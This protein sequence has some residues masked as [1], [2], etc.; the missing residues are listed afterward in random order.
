MS[1]N[2][3][4][5]VLDTSPELQPEGTYRFAMNKV[6]S[7]LDATVRDEF[8][9]KY[10]PTSSSKD[11]V[12]SVY[13]DY[14]KT[15]LFRVNRISLLTEEVE[16]VLI[17][18]ARLNIQGTQ[19]IKGVS[20]KNFRSDIIVVWTD[21]VNPVRYLNV[22]TMNLQLNSKKEFKSDSE[23]SKL[24]FFPDLQV[25]DVPRVKVNDAGGTL[26]SGTYSLAIAYQT[27]DNFITD[28]CF[29]SNP[30]FITGGVSSQEFKK[31]AGVK[32]SSPTTK[33]ITFSVD[34]LDLNFPKVVYAIIQ[35]NGTEESAFIAMVKDIPKIGT[36]SF[37]FTGSEFVEQLTVEDVLIKKA[38]YTSAKTLTIT[39]DQLWFANLKTKP[40]IDYQQYANNIKAEWVYADHVSLNGVRGSYKDGNVIY[41]DKSFM[42]GEVVSL[43]I[44]LIRKNGQRT[45]AFHIPGRLPRPINLERPELENTLV[46][47]L[48][49]TYPDMEYLRKDYNISEEA[50]YFH[51][52]DT[53]SKR[54]FES[55]L[56]GEM[57][58]WENEEVYPD[59][60]PE[61]AGLP[62]RHHRLPSIGSLINFG[63]SLMDE[64]LTE[65]TAAKFVL[66]INTGSTELSGNQ[67]FMTLQQ[68]RINFNRG[69]DVTVS[70][71]VKLVSDGLNH[72]EAFAVIKLFSADGSLK[73]VLLNQ[74]E[75]DNS[76][77]GSYVLVA[78]IES[79]NS[80]FVAVD[81]GDYLEYSFFGGITREGS[82]TIN[83][84]EKMLSD[85]GTIFSKKLGIALWNIQIPQELEDEI[86]GY[87]IFYGK[88]DFNNATVL[89]YSPIID[90]NSPNFATN[91]IPGAKV[92]L[93]SPDFLAN[94]TYPS[95]PV[96]YLCTE[97]GITGKDEQSPNRM[98]DYSTGMLNQ[99]YYPVTDVD[100][101][102]LKVT[103]VLY[104][105]Y[106]PDTM[107]ATSL[108]C[109]VVNG[110]TTTGRAYVSLRV[111]RKN[112]YTTFYSTPL[113]STG[114]IF[115]TPEPGIYATGSLYGGDTYFGE[116]AF[117]KSKFVDIDNEGN[118]E[119][120]GY[121]NLDAVYSWFTFSVLN[122]NLRYAGENFGEQYYPLSN[123]PQSFLTGGDTFALKHCCTVDNYVRIDPLTK[124][125][126][127][128]HG[129]FVFN[130][131]V[132][133]T[134]IFPNRIA[135][136]SLIA[137][138][139]SGSSAK[140]FLVLDYYEM[141]KNKGE[142]VN[143]EWFN[144]TLLIHHEDAL[145]TTVPETRMFTKD[146]EVALGTGKLFSM[147]PKA[148]FTVEGGYAG[149]QHMGS[150]R[151]TKAGYFFVDDRR[152]KVFLL[153]D[154][155]KEISNSGMKTFFR[156]NSI[157]YMTKGDAP[158]LTGGVGY[159]VGFDDTFNRI[160]LHKKDFIIDGERTKSNNYTLSYSIE[161]EKWVSFHSY[162]PNHLFVH[163]NKLYAAKGYNLF[164]HND[165]ETRATYYNDEQQKTFV[166]IVFNPPTSFKKLFYAFLWDTSCYD[167]N[168][169]LHP[170]N[171][172]DKVLVY[173]NLQVSGEVGLD[174]KIR[175]LDGSWR[176]NQF[177][178]L[179]PQEKYGKNFLDKTGMFNS[180]V[181]D[182]QMDYRI[183]KRFIGDWIILRLINTNSDNYIVYLHSSDAFF[184]KIS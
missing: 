171:T 151:V 99:N 155:L 108:S 129:I 126:N 107:R 83:A 152:G 104:E 39:N 25:P 125:L 184:R 95:M 19:Q 35:R 165:P 58:Y 181:V 133:Y 40:Q 1:R 113:V 127:T 143:I 166:D 132:N 59:W 88:R 135:G 86:I 174:G 117:F 87:E 76:D 177:R 65:S 134:Y 98:I 161:S 30:V 147:A 22:S 33:S 123:I 122:T 77:D 17:S 26:I 145:F 91:L 70:W 82:I 41:L 84:L 38:H 51:M 172:F 9:T 49:E 24:N 71:D 34:N 131:D 137:S 57:G 8:G 158:F 36:D 116:Y 173:N 167:S 60:F 101:K 139:D 37:E 63:T 12:G 23:V 94:E 78:T 153:N 175:Q 79:K 164:M 66:D 119:D 142:I 93:Y 16:E 180:D 53:S 156:Q 102:V 92:N 118:Y 111:F 67:S 97:L 11:I 20:F 2:Y 89:A 32:P 157:E 109:K 54:L 68:S 178:D 61:Y 169:D 136:G 128:D 69:L 176:F 42:P 31:Y 183:Q 162:S 15:L 44:S 5:M 105:P 6:V 18:D 120:P 47:K 27:D 170:G 130:R 114:R 168:M 56:R 10:I 13:I 81:E 52:R 163:R 106:A 148:I 85:T 146:Y 138:E 28:F 121:C 154:G 141:S 64:N 14:N 50:R 74:V 103:D 73:R 90:Y 62:V 140:K 3:L 80:V 55:Q 75:E 43:Y 100:Q 124:K 46:S 149:T 48:I 179:V 159:S 182:P 160:I 115:R 7:Y 110:L 72:V 96:S 112:I 45:E 150:C 29:V 4:G 21:S 144:D